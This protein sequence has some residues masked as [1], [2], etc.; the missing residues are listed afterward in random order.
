M[1]TLR[2]SR[3]WLLRTRR[4]WFGVVGFLLLVAMWIRSTTHQDLLVLESRNA[5]GSEKSY[6]AG[7]ED[8]AL[9]V[10]YVGFDRPSTYLKPYFKFT[11]S[12]L[13]RSFKSGSF[14]RPTIFTI[15]GVTT[16]IFS[17]PLWIPPLLWLIVWPWWVSRLNHKEAAYFAK[18]VRESEIGAQ[19]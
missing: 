15:E 5:K 8:G 6:V 7:N 9:I 16:C 13:K 11:P 10:G 19:K 14:S 4:F 3:W 1:N 17:I 12:T 2:R 18:T